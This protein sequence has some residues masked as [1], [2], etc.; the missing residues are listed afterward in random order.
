MAMRA[1]SAIDMSIARHTRSSLVTLKD[2]SENSR[3]TDDS[4]NPSAR[5][6]RPYVIPRARKQR[7]NVSSNRRVSFTASSWVV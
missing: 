2:S 4:L 3:F 6:S 5:P 7:F 1:R